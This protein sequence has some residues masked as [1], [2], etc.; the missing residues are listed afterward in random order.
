MLLASSTQLSARGYL[1]LPTKL[2]TRASTVCFRFPIVRPPTCLWCLKL[3][4]A[5]ST[6]ITALGYFVLQTPAERTCFLRA[7][8]GAQ[9]V[10]FPVL[11]IGAQIST[12]GYLVSRANSQCHL[13]VAERSLLVSALDSGQ[14]RYISHFCQCGR[15]HVSCISSFYL[16]AHKSRHVGMLSRLH[17]GTWAFFRRILFEVIVGT[18]LYS[19]AAAPIKPTFA[20]RPCALL[21]CPWLQA[22]FHM[23]DI[24]CSS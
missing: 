6:R 3:A 11:A 17:V 21:H 14:A 15:Q 4:K 8:F 22:R 5:S 13:A 1:V 24:H 16:L 12:R 20:L 23:E 19:G 10:I 18:I 9:Q 7:G 2:G